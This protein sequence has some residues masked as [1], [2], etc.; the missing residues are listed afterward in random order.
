LDLG[1]AGIWND[2]DEPAVFNVPSGTMPLDL[3]FDNEGQPTTHREIHN[4]YGQLM[5]RATFEGLSRLRP[6]A[7]PFVLTRASFAGGQRYAAVW[8]GDNTSEW[9][10][11]RQSISTLLGLGLSGFSFAGCD[12]GGFDGAPSGELFTRWLQ[13]GVFYPFMR[14]HSTLGSPDKEPWAFGYRNELINR[15]AIELRYELLPYIYNAM[16]QASETGVPAMRPLFLE[17]PGD[18][19]VAGMGDEFLFGADLLVA[20]V[21][22]QGAT[23]RDVYLPH[24]DWFDYW[25]GRKFNGN[26][27][28]HVPVTIESIPIYVRG[29]GFIFREPVIQFTGQMPGQPLKVLVAPAKD[30]TASFYEDDGESLDYKKGDFM[31]RRFHQVRDSHGITIDVSAPVGNY[32]PAARDLV[33]QLWTVSEP[34]AVFN[35]IGDLGSEKISLPRLPLDALRKAPNGWSFEDNLLTVKVGDRFQPMCFNIDVRAPR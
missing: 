22:Y 29:G 31:K 24:G 3:V 33:L 15:R 32:R 23:E 13:A 12:I 9:S 7:R 1:V 19:N 28:I 16:H 27:T 21:L 11:L 20:P 25:T 30:S 6:D 2:M 34:K 17:F 35:Q 14:A 10:S 8:P 4:V 5:S 26:Q 18:A